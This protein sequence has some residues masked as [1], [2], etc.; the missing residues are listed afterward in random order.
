MASL[1]LVAMSIGSR[2]ALSNNG[3]IYENIIHANS[4]VGITEQGGLIDFQIYSNT[5]FDNNSN[6]RIHNLDSSDYRRVYIYNN[7]MYQIGN[8][9]NQ[10]FLHAFTQSP[11]PSK[12]P[13]NYIYH[14]SISGGE[15]SI[16]PDAYVQEYGGVPN[17]Y[18]VNN[19]FSSKLLM[20]NTRLYD[21]KSGL[22]IFDYNWVSGKT[23]PSEWYGDKNVSSGG[24]NMWS[25]DSVPNFSL[26]SGTAKSIGLDISK[27]NTVSGK[28]LNAMLG[29]KDGYFSGFKPD[30]GYTPGLTGDTFRVDEFVIQ[31]G[32]C[33]TVI[34]QCLA[35]SFQDEIDSS[36]KNI[37]SCLGINGGLKAMC[38]VDK[39]NLNTLYVSTS[40]SD[41]SGDGSSAKPFSTLQKAIDVAVA[42]DR[43]FIKAGIYDGRRI[44]LKNSGSAGKPIV[45]EGETSSS[46][47]RLVTLDGGE[48]MTGWVSAPVI[49]FEGIYR[50]AERMSQSWSHSC[51]VNI[52]RQ[53]APNNLC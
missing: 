51:G 46:G 10:F 37:W 45:I 31:N 17:F 47:E 53:S 41:T 6:I 3:K 40:G 13:E 43:I 33:S 20:C 2:G 26:I 35:G 36:V 14:N 12:N 24:V 5:I 39:S 32:Q 25:V 30:A 27:A 16:C 44:T 23:F 38:S 1:G 7:K 4:S 48:A 28:N 42:G 22:G 29:A 9:G 52:G 11:R 34:N 49:C 21:L 18:F 8:V 19:I 15:S 50:E